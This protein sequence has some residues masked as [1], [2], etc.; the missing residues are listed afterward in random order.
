MNTF[1]RSFKLTFGRFR[2]E[3]LAYWIF[4]IGLVAGFA[5]EILKQAPPPAFGRSFRYPPDWAKLEMLAAC[6]I[7][8]RLM[9]SEPVFRTQG[10]WRS[11]PISRDVAILT[12][13]AVLIAV[14]LPSLLVRLFFI[15]WETTPDAALWW[16]LFRDH[17]LWGMLLFAV[18]AMVLRLAGSLLRGRKRGLAG[19]IVFAIAGLCVMGAWFHP[20]TARMFFN[21]TFSYPNRD[22]R[23]QDR[24]YGDL[25]PGLREVLPANARLLEPRGAPYKKEVPHTP[26]MVR[27]IPMEGTVARGAGMSV[28]VM[29]VTPQGQGVEIEMAIDTIASG[30]MI[31]ISGGVMLL[32]FPGEIYS[33]R[34][35]IKDSRT[36]YPVSC[37]PLGKLHCTGTFAAPMANPD[38]DKLLPGLE[39]IIYRQDYDSPLIT[40][41]GDEMPKEVKVE[42]PR[43][44]PPRLPPGAEGDV[45]TIFDGFDFDPQWEKREAMKARGATMTREAMPHVLARHPWSD[46]AW[47]LFVRPFLLKHADDSD[48]AKLLERMTTE[49]RLGEIFVAKGWKADAMPLLKRFA[50]DRL[51]LDAVSV[52]ALLEEKDPGLAADVAALA[53][54]LDEGVEKMEPLLK[55][56]PGLDWKNFVHD[57]WMRR[58]YAF[59]MRGPIHPFDQWAAQAGD[60]SAFRYI[61]EKAARKETEYEECLRSLLTGEHADAVGFVRENLAELKFDAKSGKWGQ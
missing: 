11:R 25:L 45:A 34:Q 51:P 55:E 20:K 36:V 60:A 22:M 18:A 52:N 43:P 9:F 26:E 59:R 15:T 1:I 47:E 5:T 61:A 39:L 7:I 21:S 50:K 40:G 33:F 6:W 35:K 56:Y 28:E 31:D 44:S 14:L 54:R 16:R 37:F 8:L 41:Y 12:P 24:S 13:Y 32:R 3:I 49:P 17:F 4:S 19:K 53:A 57:G 2:W 30:G 42:A 38:W 48:K 46:L 27:F 29:R 58:K 10:G 23:G